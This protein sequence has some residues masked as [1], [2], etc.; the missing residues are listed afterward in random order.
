MA[1]T[2]DTLHL[3]TQIVGKT[4]LALARRCRTTGGRWRSTSPPRPDDVAHSR[5]RRAPSRSTSTSSTTC[6]WCAPATAR[7]APLPW[8]RSPWPTSIATTGRLLRALGAGRRA[9][10][11]SRRDG[12]RDPLRPTTAPTPPTTPTPRSAAGGR[13]VQVD[14][15]LQA[16]S[17]AAS[18][19]SAAPSTSG[20]ARFDLAVHALLGPPARRPTPAASP[21]SPTGDAR[22]LL[23]RVHQ[24]G[25][26]AGRRRGS[27]SRPSTPTPIP[28]RRACRR[29]RCGPPPRATTRSCASSSC[30]TRRCAPRADPDAALLEFL[31]ST[32][33][34]AA[35][36]GG[37]DRAAL[38]RRTCFVRRTGWGP[39]RRARCPCR[40]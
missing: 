23:A 20:G 38:E 37:W 40:R 22:G 16:R 6:W 4:R 31:Q 35:D 32:Y 26:V 12:D 14:R 34:A 7:R 2:Y 33:E 30:P 5:R 29:R 3:W 9:S 8:R 28:S 13:C 24:R 17:A 11:P 25:L 36:L 19:A 15:V 18:S 27:T 1:A 39:A 10:G 21:T